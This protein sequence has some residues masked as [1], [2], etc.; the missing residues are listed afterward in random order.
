MYNIQSVAKNEP[1]LNE[2]KITVYICA[3]FVYERK[4]KETIKLNWMG[5]LRNV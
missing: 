4:S 3:C 5:C 2:M 1:A